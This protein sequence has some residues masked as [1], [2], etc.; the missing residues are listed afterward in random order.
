MV[1]KSYCSIVCTK[2]R[3]QLNV[4]RDKKSGRICQ[5]TMVVTLESR[6]DKGGYQ[7]G[8]FHFLLYMLEFNWNTPRVLYYFINRFKKEKH[9]TESLGFKSSLSYAT[10]G[11]HLHSAEPVSSSENQNKHLQNCS[12]NSRKLETNERLVF[13]VTCPESRQK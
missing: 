3:Y 8:D 13:C 11:N 6:L 2:A 10:S 5:P 9:L 12:A 4:N 7:R 1:R